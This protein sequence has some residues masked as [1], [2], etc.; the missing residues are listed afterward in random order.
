M[1]VQDKN[2]KMSDIRLASGGAKESV[3]KSTV[4]IPVDIS[5]CN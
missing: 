5:K 2:I 4:V 1:K 3:K